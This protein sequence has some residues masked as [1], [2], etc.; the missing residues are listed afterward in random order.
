MSHIEHPKNEKTFVILK[1]DSIQRGLVGEIIQRYERIGLKCVAL[2]MV[3][4]T[5]EM[6]A[7]HYTI[8]PEWIHK[9]GDK[10]IKKYLGKG[11]T[12]PESDPLKVGHI[13]LDNLKRYMSSGPV[14]VMVWQG[15]HAVE[16]VRKLTGGTEPLTSDIGTIRGDYV[17]D[18]YEMSD[19]DGRS[20]RNVVHASGNVD[21]A[22]KEIELWFKPEEVIKYKHIQEAILYDKHITGILED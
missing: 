16:I 17:L 10:S 13:V 6:V 15:A 20:I 22:N 5:P 4:A 12:P 21:E 18:S 2:K 19:H 1:P 11:M 14:V 3:L 7:K 9:A 8:D